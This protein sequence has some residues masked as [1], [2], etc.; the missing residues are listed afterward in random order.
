MLKK[1]LFQVLLFGFLFC[2][3]FYTHRFILESNEI[4]IQLP[5]FQIYLFHGIFSLI[6]CASFQILSSYEKFASQLGF[7]Y[8]GTFLLK[9]LLFAIIFNGLLFNNEANSLTNKISLLAPVFIF[10]LFEVIIIAK[11]LGK[12][13]YENK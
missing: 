9:L 11:I 1:V 13:E 7:I 8:L 4:L 5:L 6:I 3:G 10:L 12:A 2:S